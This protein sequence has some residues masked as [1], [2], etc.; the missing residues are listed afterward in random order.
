MSSALGGAQLK[1]C[2]AGFYGS[3]AARW[4]LA[5]CW[6][7]GGL[8]L[9][10]RLAEQLQLSADSRL[11]DVACGTGGSALMIADTFGCQVHG[12]D[13]S[14]R[15]VEQAT[16]AAAERGLCARASFELGDAEGLSVASQRF[17]ALL[18]EC[19]LCTFPDK[20]AAAGE[21]HRVLRVGGRLALSDVTRR[22][23]ALTG[24]DDLAGWVACIAD[25]LPLP[26]YAQCLLEAGFCEVQ[27]EDRSDTLQALIE[28]IA[29]R[30]AAGEL[31]AGLAQVPLSAG[32]LQQAR[33]LLTTAHEAVRRGQ[34][35]YGVVTARK[36]A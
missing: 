33:G 36:G 35:G 9:T 23:A 20:R 22:P 24:L 25:A 16:R 2:C 34:L 31:L 21:F 10:R 12:V 18:C 5:D 1:Q 6:H 32:E 8:E 30:L 15:N 14:A 11:L 26:A 4:L 13:L 3:D 27:T 17:D 29:G 19:A 7:P 28:R